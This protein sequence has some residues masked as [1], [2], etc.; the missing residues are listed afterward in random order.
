MDDIVCI[1]RKQD[2]LKQITFCVKCG[3]LIYENVKSN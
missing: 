2:K 1:H 3:V